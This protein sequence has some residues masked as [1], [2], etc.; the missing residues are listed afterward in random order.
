MLQLDI[1]TLYDKEA[2]PSTLVDKIIKDQLPFCRRLGED[3]DEDSSDYH[4]LF[5]YD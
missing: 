5:D 2:H 1:C 3:L 4:T